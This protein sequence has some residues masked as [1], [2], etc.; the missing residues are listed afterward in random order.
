VTDKLYEVVQFG[1]QG[2]PGAPSTVPGPTG[3]AGVGN[4]TLL[5]DYALPNVGQLA[6]AN[7]A[8]T[9]AMVPGQVVAIDQLGALQVIGVVDPTH[10]NL[11]NLGYPG[12]A[13]PGTVAPTGSL[14]APS[15]KQGPA[16]PTGVKGDTG[17]QG[18]A[19]AGGGSAIVNAIATGDVTLN[20]F[21]NQLQLVDTTSASVT[22]TANAA[23]T[24]SN[25][26][27]VVWAKGG[28]APTFAGGGPLVRNPE[29]G[30]W[31]T[32]YAFGPLERQVQWTLF[33]FGTPDGLRW[34]VT[35]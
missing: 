21:P 11:K 9:A 16:G 10:V 33:D 12:N 29:T 32:A 30:A 26:V 23:A 27:N 25:V 7:V 2:P 34:E 35:G 5:A 1:L 14:V 22:V 18:P 31:D 13:D 15:G 3:P 17:P 4:T 8:T 6:V 19:G 20:P 28:T 24:V